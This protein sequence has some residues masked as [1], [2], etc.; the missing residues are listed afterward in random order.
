MV[1]PGQYARITEL[2]PGLQ[3]LQ[4]AVGGLI[5]C[6]YPWQEMACIVCNDEGLINGMPLNRFIPDYGPI[7]GP[8]FVCGLDK[9]NFCGLTEEQAER[10]QKMF[11]KPQMFL[12]CGNGLRYLTY[13][14]PSL[15]GAPNTLEQEYGERNGLPQYCF[16]T[17][18]GEDKIILLQYGEQGY[19]RIENEESRTAQEHVD[20]L[21]QSLGVNKAQQAAMLWG[22]MFGWDIPAADPHRYDEKGTPKPM[23]EDQNKEER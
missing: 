14:D 6:T 4:K 13:D 15:P 8:F 11:L 21:N 9:E 5:D 23:K 2:D 17:L 20:Q 16:S 12:H 19:Y 18:P 22:S 1:E 7:A 3:S 10:F